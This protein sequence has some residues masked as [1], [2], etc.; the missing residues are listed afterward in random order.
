MECIYLVTSNW[1]S[2]H[3]KKGLW[4][5]T[6]AQREVV[7]PSQTV[8]PSSYSNYFLSSGTESQ[9]PWIFDSV[10]DMLY[11][12][13][14]TISSVFLVYHVSGCQ[15]GPLACSPLLHSA[16][17]QPSPTAHS[18]LTST[19]PRVH[20]SATFPTLPPAFL[21]QCHTSVSHSTG[22]SLKWRDDAHVSMNFSSLQLLFPRSHVLRQGI[23]VR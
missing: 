2:F 21:R 10:T 16:N 15:L 4:L 12:L 14:L 17:S 20:F 22:N 19:F 11:Y 6:A 5:L 13:Q 7:L 18:Y 3:L 1:K 23:A 8:C 9:P